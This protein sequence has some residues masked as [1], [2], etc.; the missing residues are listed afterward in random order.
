ME[1]EER[2]P[3]NAEIDRLAST[4]L[5]VQLV[6]SERQDAM[7]RCQH[8]ADA[9]PTMKTAISTSMKPFPWLITSL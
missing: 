8:V 1:V 4:A 9:Q 6:E 7:E 5:P 2:C 3:S